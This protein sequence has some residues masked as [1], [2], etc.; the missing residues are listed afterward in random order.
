VINKPEWLRKNL[1]SEENVLR[2]K[3]IKNN[4]NNLNGI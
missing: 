1:S 3:E 2:N 4:N